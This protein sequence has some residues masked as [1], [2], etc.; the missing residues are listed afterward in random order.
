[1]GTQVLKAHLGPGD[2]VPGSGSQL[3]SMSWN[4]EGWRE[5]RLSV[6]CAE[7]GRAGEAEA[8]S[9]SHQV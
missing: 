7:V 5:Q 3:T 8:V 1:M 9:D 2:Q 6:L 4:S